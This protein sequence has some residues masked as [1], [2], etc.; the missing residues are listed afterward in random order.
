HAR[1][2]HTLEERVLAQARGF[3]GRFQSYNYQRGNLEI[4]DRK[5][6]HRP[7]SAV[8][9]RHYANAMRNAMSQDA[10][11][12]RSTESPY[13]D[14]LNHLGIQYDKNAPMGVS[15]E[16]MGIIGP[17]STILRLEREWSALEAA[18]QAKYGKST[19]A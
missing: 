19:K 9:Q 2:V 3:P 13:L 17:D 11:L 6:H 8:C 1:C 16:E 12:G 5:A 4:L 18:L 14:I 15:D 10:G 7:N